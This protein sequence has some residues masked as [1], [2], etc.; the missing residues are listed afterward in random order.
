MKAYLF[1]NRKDRS[2]LLLPDISQEVPWG[3]INGECLDVAEW[4]T[5]EN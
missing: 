1:P 4:G 2:H 3:G 5:R